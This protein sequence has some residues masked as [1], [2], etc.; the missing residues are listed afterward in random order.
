MALSI[1]ANTSVSLAGTT[2]SLAQAATTQ[3]TPNG[4]GSVNSIVVQPPASQSATLKA[5]LSAV[6]LQAGLADDLQD[7]SSA[8][9]TSMRTIV[10]QR[11]DLATAQFDFKSN[12]E[13]IQVVSS[14]LNDADKAWLQQTLNANGALVTVV[15]TFHDN[16]V[17]S[18]GEFATAAGQSLSATDQDKASTLAD[19]SFGFMSMFTRAGQAQM[20]GM[21]PHGQY[22]T[23]AGTPIDFHQPANS[24]LG[25]LVFQK[26]SEAIQAGT[27]SYTTSTG[28][29]FYG[30]LKGNMFSLPGAIPNFVPGNRSN[31]MG[32][33]VTA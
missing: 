13:S 1:P 28:R 25:F 9:V 16:A 11:P 29:T 18:Y 19:Q 32:L 33:S 5:A 21:D 24:A 31:S 6:S 22:T 12:N 3:A 23:A 26:S 27:V 15:K 7:V 10:E 17:K 14:T 30:A 20:T 8:L 4:A 2:A